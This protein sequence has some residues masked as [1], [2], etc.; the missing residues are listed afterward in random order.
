MA[1]SDAF[2]GP[3]PDVAGPGAKPSGSARRWPW[4]LVGLLIL[5]WMVHRT[6]V[7]DTLSW[8]R[9]ELPWLVLAVVLNAANLLPKIARWRAFLG[10]LGHV[11]PWWAAARACVVSTALGLFTPGRV[12]DLLRLRY[13]RDDVGLGYASGFGAMVVDR[14][15]DV[16]VLGVIAGASGLRLLSRPQAELT[17]WWAA[18]VVAGLGFSAV[19]ISVVGRRDSTLRG[20]L[21]RRGVHPQ[22]IARTLEAIQGTARGGTL[23]AGLVA[24]TLAFAI[25]FLQGWCVS[26][27]LGLD[28]AYADIAMM[29]SLASFLS[30]VPIS[31][32]GIGVREAFLS[33]VVPLVGGTAADGVGLGLLLTFVV[34]VAIGVG[35]GLTA[36]VFP[37]PGSR[38]PGPASSS[39]GAVGP[40]PS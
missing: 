12:G 33:T 36:L 6:R 8:E 26:R 9:I 25:F 14:A 23:A 30:L 11:Y 28:L 24:T 32:A 15:C 40:R 34:Y 2:E 13:A 3:A 1:D 17:L 20:W 4:R 10:R 31:I 39:G 16:A 5:G 18:L 27:A 38:G 19:V 7:F 29:L 37:G 21:D 22:R 35:G